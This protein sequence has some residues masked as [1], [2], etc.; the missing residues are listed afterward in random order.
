MPGS[1]RG[2]P[3]RPAL[4]ILAAILALVLGGCYWPAPGQGP[5]RQ[6]Y[7]VAERAIGPDTV[8]SL[9]RIWARS[10]GTGSA[11]DPV[12]STAGVHVADAARVYLLDAATGD[13]EHSVLPPAPLSETQ[14]IVNG[15]TLLTGQWNKTIS[16]ND[17]ADED[18]TVPRSP[19]TL[20]NAGASLPGL[21]LSTRGNL[22]LFWDVELFGGPTARFWGGFIRV[23]DLRDGALLCCE[24]VLKT[25]SANPPP[26]PP[27]PLTLGRRSV[28]NAGQGI[29]DP[30]NPTT[31][32]GNGL[33]EFAIR[34]DGS[35]PSFPGLYLC[36]DRAV[37]LD[38]S[39]A[40]APVLADEER[41]SRTSARTL[42]RSTRSIS[43]RSQCS[44]LGPSG[45]R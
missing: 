41:V 28:F 36:P 1:R 21:P 44:G 25:S 29:N 40:T 7:N 35:C 30:A 8:G 10:L 34:T 20:E 39:A 26:P 13:I 4:T 14:P 37:A 22:G 18:V 31:S 5:D 33:R 24:G 32:F 43:I 19:A 45:R 9:H 12:T 23:R 15:K 42:A 3:S 27:E 2:G 38:G 11:S 17:D 16:A 6:S